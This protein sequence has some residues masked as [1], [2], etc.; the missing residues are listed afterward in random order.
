VI[1]CLAL[2][3]ALHSTRTD[4]DTGPSW[5]KA[6]PWVS[7]QPL[8]L[9]RHFFGLMDRLLTPVKISFSLTF[10]G[11]ASETLRAESC[12][13]STAQPPSVQHNGSTVLTR[14]KSQVPSVVNITLKDDGSIGCLASRQIKARR[15]LS[16][17]TVAII[18]SEEI[19]SQMAL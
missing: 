13:L 14:D 5:S 3:A 18:L 10:T 17:L 9:V 12:V 4:R 1:S 11:P 6:N 8:L 15:E 16:L 19:T 7:E 2:P